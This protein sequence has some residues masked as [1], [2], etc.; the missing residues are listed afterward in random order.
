MANK[1]VTARCMSGNEEMETI[2]TLSSGIAH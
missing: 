1:I 2:V